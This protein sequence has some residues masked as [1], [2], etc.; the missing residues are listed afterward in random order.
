MFGKARRTSGSRHR[1]WSRTESS[2]VSPGSFHQS[3]TRCQERHTRRDFSHG[4]HSTRIPGLVSRHECDRR[5][6]LDDDGGASRTNNR[7]WL[8]AAPRPCARAGTG[9][10]LGRAP[11]RDLG[12]ASGRT[13][14]AR[15]PQPR[16]S[17]LQS[18]AVISFPSLNWTYKQ[19]QMRLLGHIQG[20]GKEARNNFET[21]ASP[22][23]RWGHRPPF[24]PPTAAHPWTI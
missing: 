15:Q 16:R 12:P 7:H 3:R 23:D 20:V 21:H 14:M 8:P 10:W 17:P 22:G 5:F 24:W 18:G 11:G 2:L 6:M 13:A 1:R 19:M 4:S 9:P